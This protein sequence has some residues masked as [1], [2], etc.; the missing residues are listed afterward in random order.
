MHHKKT[1]ISV[2]IGILQEDQLYTNI[3]IKKKQL[4]HTPRGDNYI[5][6]YINISREYCYTCINVYT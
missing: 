5:Y 3:L 4:I 2:L 6:F 1:T